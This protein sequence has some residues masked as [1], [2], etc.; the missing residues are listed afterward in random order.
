M[1]FAF[2][3]DVSTSTMPPSMRCASAGRPLI[4][5]SYRSRRP[6][7]SAL[8]TSYSAPV[9]RLRASVALSACAMRRS[10]MPARR[11][12]SCLRQ[13][14][15]ARSC[16]AA[17]SAAWRSYGACGSYGA[18]MPAVCSGDAPRAATM[19]AAMRARRCCS[20]MA[21]DSA[22]T[23]A[24]PS[25]AAGMP[26]CDGAPISSSSGSAPVACSAISSPGASMD[27]PS[28]SS[29]AMT[30]GARSGVDDCGAGPLIGG[31]NCIGGAPTSMSSSSSAGCAG[32]CG[33]TGGATGAACGVCG[34][35]CCARP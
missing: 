11:S 10:S 24:M 29:D 25:S 6:C 1:V 28:S 17:C 23:D 12:S 31:R 33:A 9:R 30:P 19:V 13:S 32:A 22:C 8:S 27:S 16:C 15:S 7:A 5:A 2:H 26:F 4:V 14:A 18:V 34:A 20:R 3:P 35:C 21:C